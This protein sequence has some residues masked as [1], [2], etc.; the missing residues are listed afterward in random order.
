[1]GFSRN[2]GEIKYKIGK[3]DEILEE[4]GNQYRYGHLAALLRDT[5]GEGEGG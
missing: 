5:R 4:K 1:M 2:N 3:V